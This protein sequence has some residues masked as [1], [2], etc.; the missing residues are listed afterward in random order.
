MKNQ[1]PALWLEL[2]AT[3]ALLIWVVLAGV[4]LNRCVG[5]RAPGD[6]VARPDRLGKVRAVVEDPRSGIP[7]DVRHRLLDLLDSSRITEG[8]EV[9]GRQ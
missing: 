4:L 5:G 8:K 6:R 2:L 3:L 9:G 7:P 1:V